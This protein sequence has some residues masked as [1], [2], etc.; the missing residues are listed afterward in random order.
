M[1]STLIIIIVTFLMI[2]TSLENNELIAQT[3]TKY[4]NETIKTI[5]SRKS[6]RHFTDKKVSKEQL[7]TIVKAG[8]AAPTAMNGQPWEFYVVTE[9][10]ILDELVKGLPNS[11]ML[12]QA[13]AAI[14]VCGHTEKNGKID[15]S[16][17]WMLDCAN[18]SEN[19]LLAI[20]SMG[21]GGLWTALYPD[22]ERMDF[23]RKT[24]NIPQ[25]IMPLNCIP[26]GYPTGED[27][28]KDK[29]N[30]EKIH[31]NIW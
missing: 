11:Q 8:M 20:E 9:R 28:A 1:K 2:L 22:N 12:K 24:L 26:I 27:K 21:L 17:F 14:I 13:S 18:A 3:Q 16:Q 31:W 10:K 4:P 25:N 30:A 6:V 23:A 5:H 29:Y 19:M 7:E 15:E